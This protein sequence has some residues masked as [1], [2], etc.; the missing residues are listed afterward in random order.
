MLAWNPERV[1]FAHGKWYQDDG[2]RRLRHAF[3]NFLT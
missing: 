2:E 1:I 3:R